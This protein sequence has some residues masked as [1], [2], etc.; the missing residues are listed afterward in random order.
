MIPK[1]CVLPLLLALA[2]CQPASTDAASTDAKQADSKQADP[3]QADAKPA[4]ATPAADAERPTLKIATLEGAQYDLASKRGG[5]VVVNFWATWCA[6][7]IKEM[8]ELDAFDAERADVEVIGLAYEEIAVEEMR[9]FLKQ[10]PVRYPIAL[11]DTYDPPADFPTPRGLPMTYV[12]APD[13]RI[14]KSFMGPV[15]GTELAAVIDAP[16]G[17]PAAKPEG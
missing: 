3:K 1:Y 7:C 12:I 10:R 2:A 16:A 17:A 6:P 8:P 15:T 13:G 9:A 4:D 5:W 14:A 11:V